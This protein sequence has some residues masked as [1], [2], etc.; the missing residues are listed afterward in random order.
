MAN[1]KWLTFVCSGWSAG[2]TGNVPSYGKKRLSTEPARWCKISVEI[3]LAALTTTKCATFKDVFWTFWPT[4]GSQKPPKSLCRM[5][6][7]SALRKCC[8]SFATF[9]RLQTNLWSPTHNRP[10]TVHGPK[11]PKARRPP[12]KR[13]CNNFQ[14]PAALARRNYALRISRRPCFAD[15]SL[16]SSRSCMHCK[17]L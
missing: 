5:A 9:I 12:S 8:R 15:P 2:A 1:F 10:R 7:I 13:S 6:C 17:F 11:A 14:R 16:R 4:K 3:T